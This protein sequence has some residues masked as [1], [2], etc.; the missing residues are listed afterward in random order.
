MEPSLAFVMELLKRD[1]TIAYMSVASD[2]RRGLVLLGP[3]SMAPNLAE[4]KNSKIVSK[5]YRDEKADR[6]WS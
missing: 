1:L 6:V 4:L 2:V 3:R 5:V